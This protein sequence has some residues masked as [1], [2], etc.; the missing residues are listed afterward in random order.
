MDSIGLENGSIA[1][2]V[3]NLMVQIRKLRKAEDVS[4]CIIYRGL[5]TRLR[6]NAVGGGDDATTIVCGLS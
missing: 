5:K 3:E 2:D 6:G 1:A 4:S